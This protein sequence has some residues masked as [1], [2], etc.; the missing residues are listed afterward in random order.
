VRGHSEIAARRTDGHG[1]PADIIQPQDPIASS[2]RSDHV[3]ASGA[4]LS[5]LPLLHGVER[6]GDQHPDMRR[7]CS[8]GRPKSWLWPS[9]PEGEG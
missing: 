4:K 1:D 7:S 6:Y 2:A 9:P 3:D 5:W 8:W